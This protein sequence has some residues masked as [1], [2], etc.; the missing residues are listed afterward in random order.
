MFN[1]IKGLFTANGD[2]D[3]SGWFDQME[4]ECKVSKVEVEPL[5]NI[6]EPVY[7]MVKSINERPHSWKVAL[8]VDLHPVAF[9]SIYYTIKDK[10]T[11]L[12]FTASKPR[13]FHYGYEQPYKVKL[14]WITDDEAGYLCNALED[15]QQ[16]KMKRLRNI[17][18]IKKDI[19]AT[20]DRQAVKEL[21]N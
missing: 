15:M 12:S 2:M 3:M 9:R 8:Q 21:Y 14:D 10:V 5:K 16:G 13:S 11:G 17:A 20:I 6:S 4:A 19:Q 18:R 1:W 7:A